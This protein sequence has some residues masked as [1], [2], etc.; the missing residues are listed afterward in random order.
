MFLAV[1]STTW[2][3]SAECSNS[4]AVVALPDLNLFL[5]AKQKNK[6]TTH[7]KWYDD[8]KMNED[9]WQKWWM[10]KKKEKRW[11]LNMLRD[12]KWNSHTDLIKMEEAAAYEHSCL[13]THMNN[14][15][16]SSQ[17]PHHHNWCYPQRAQ[18]NRVV[19]TWSH[20]RNSQ[21]IFC[22]NPP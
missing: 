11:A 2:Y 1:S 22:K 20:A 12:K 21:H 7:L 6:K 14:P 19:C 9:F 8:I 17:H 13:Q 16:T 5:Y 10:E 3:G 15:F 4:S 18:E